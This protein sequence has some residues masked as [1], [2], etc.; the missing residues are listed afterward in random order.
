MVAQVITTYPHKIL[1]FESPIKSLMIYLHELSL[2]HTFSFFVGNRVNIMYVWVKYP[3]ILWMEAIL[4][5]L[6]GGLFH[7]LKGLSMFQPSKVMQE[8]FPQ[9][10][11]QM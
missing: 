9:K 11:G 1:H 8:F 4:H 5:Q 3:I 6:I 7:H 10:N 2:F